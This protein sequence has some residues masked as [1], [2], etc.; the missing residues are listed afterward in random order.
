MSESPE[1]SYYEVAL[2]NRQ[3]VTAFVILLTCLLAAFFSG[4]WVGRGGAEPVGQ[5]IVATPP[6]EATV[7]AGTEPA[8]LDFFEDVS[9]SGNEAAGSARGAVPSSTLPTRPPAEPIATEPPP[10]A[11]ASRASSEDEA[12]APATSEKRTTEK[13]TRETAAETKKPAGSQKAKPVAKAEAKDDASRPADRA[14]EASTQKERPKVSGGDPVPAGG[15][16]FVQVFASSDRAEAIK[17][18][19]KLTAGGHKAYLSPTQVGGK[20]LYRVRVGS[21]PTRDRAQKVADRI[22]RSY[23]L[24]TWVTQ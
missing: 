1:P 24:D 9:S 12:A 15:T 3:V 20:S 22:R 11:E 2:T 6:A 10:T 5:Q 19:D 4:V 14:R 7:A 23:R 8:P 21:F 17:V 13:Q 18:R 16:F